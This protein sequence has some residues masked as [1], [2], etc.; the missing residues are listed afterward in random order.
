MQT[1]VELEVSQ[2]V[3]RTHKYTQHTRRTN[4]RFQPFPLKYTTIYI[5]TEWQA[6]KCLEHI[7]AG[8]VGFDTEFTK[9]RP[10]V[11][12]GYIENHLSTG[13]L[14]GKRT[15][16][17]GW[18]LVELRSGIFSVAWDNIGLRLVQIAH[19]QTAWVLDMWKI[20]G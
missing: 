9:R 16:M 12:E 6:N 5:T 19:E 8:D 4:Q 13:G 3:K 2:A 18:Q 15:M 14:G 7:V 17:L 10:T 1:I 20:R 11:E